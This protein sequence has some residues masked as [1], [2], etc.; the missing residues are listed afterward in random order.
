DSPALAG[1]HYEFIE[2]KNAGSLSIDLSGLQFTNG[3]HYTFPLGSVLA[4]GQLAVLA[5]D[6]AAFAA[7]YP[8]V[9]VA[10]TYT[11]NLS[12]GSDTL[13]LVDPSGA[14]IFSFT[15][16]SKAPWPVTPDGGGF[17]LVPVNPSFNPAPGT[18]SSWR[19]STEIGGSPGMDDPAPSVAPIY[20]NEALTHTDLPQLDAVELYNP[21][22]TNVDVGGW[23]LTDDRTVPQKFHIPAPAA[24]PA[25]GYRVFSENDWNPPG[26]GTNAF[27]LSS[28]GEQ[29]YLFSATTSGQLTGF[30]DGFSFGA[31]QNGVSFGRYVNSVGDVQYPAQKA[32]TLG[33]P[34]A[35][36]RIGPVVIN[37]IHYH[38]AAGDVEFVELKNITNTAVVLYDP[39][40]PTNRWRLSGTGYDFPAQTSIPAGGLLVVTGGDPAAFRA[41]YNIPG[42]VQVL[43]PYSGSLQGNGETLAL[44]RPDQPDV[45]T[46][47]G[48]IFIPYID[49]DVVR[50]DN[51]EPWP[52]A[53]AGGGSSLERKSAT[54]YGNDPIN[55]QASFG[56]PSPGRENSQNH[57]P[58]VSA[59]ADLTL[60]AAHFPLS[61]SLTGS[62]SDDGFPKP[63][64]VVALQWRQVSGPGPVVFE[65]PAATNATASFPGSGVYVLQLVGDDSDLQGSATV[66]ISIN[67]DTQPVTLSGRGSV[68]KYLDNG[69]NQGTNWTAIGFNDTA[70]ASGPA[71]LGYGDANGTQPA[72]AVGYGPSASN[73]Y[74]TTYFRRSFQVPD[75]ASVAALNV[76]VQWD[77]AAVVYLNGQEIYRD[78]FPDGPIDYL[79]TALQAVDGADETAVHTLPVDVSLLV[80]GANVLA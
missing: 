57:A 46:N 27:R 59:G 9:S 64:G 34:N 31:A 25:H 61:V 76:Q 43:G 36:P 62:V 44:Q 42:S 79:T 32:N 30:S 3:I 78:N 26:G 75:P 5:S 60:S 21:S 65:H 12:N 45:N 66:T 55:W 7:K 2:L 20:I 15:Y 8:G 71:P 17:S 38:P 29:I 39:N 1:S 68:W 6:A 37:E 73:K 19:A 28:H 22:S 69:S 48:S 70:W 23:Y 63:P 51:K 49:V 10:G 14:R 18:A 33:G 16:D 24:I 67:R 13:T 80:P 53:A 58:V 11:G 4:S 52:V 50:Y 40:Y 56:D 72:T 54:A 77:D 41:R 74:I 47:N 35:G